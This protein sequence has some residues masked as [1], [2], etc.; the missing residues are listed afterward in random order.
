MNELDKPQVDHLLSSLETISKES[1]NKVRPN[2]FLFDDLL[3]MPQRSRV[4]LLND[5]AGDIITMALRGAAPEIKECVLSAISPRQRRMIE[6]DLSATNAM[7][8]PREVAIARRRG[9]AGSNPA[10]QCRADPAQGSG[11]RIRRF[12]SRSLRQD[13]MKS[14]AELEPSAAFAIGAPNAHRC[15]LRQSGWHSSEE[16]G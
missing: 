16:N 3:A 7:I 10:G 13:N 11:T 1:V 4:M 6:S 8:N 5:I 14:A 2:I 9:G 15:G 12:D